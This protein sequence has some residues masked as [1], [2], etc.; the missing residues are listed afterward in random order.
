MKD[1]S[2]HFV[3]V[4][5]IIG[6]DN[7]GSENHSENK[8]SLKLSTLDQDSRYLTENSED[9]TKPKY[10][11]LDRV[12][13][14]ESINHGETTAEEL[15]EQEDLGEIKFVDNV[16]VKT[17]PGKRNRYFIDIKD[18]SLECPMSTCSQTFNTKTLLKAHIRKVHCATTKYVCEECG[19]G[20]TAPYLLKRHSAV[21]GSKVQC[22]ICEKWLSRRTE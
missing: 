18:D 17:R 3:N 21:H 22:G 2:Y 7:S 8:D 9:I 19:A 1:S 10:Y 4:E 15:G 20:F 16:I 5:E 6:Q 12:V 11:R 13:F 14:A